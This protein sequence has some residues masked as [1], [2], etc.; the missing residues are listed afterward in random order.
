MRSDRLATSLGHVVPSPGLRDLREVSWP[1]HGV[2]VKTIEKETAQPS[3]TRC[4]GHCCK[5]FPLPFGPVELWTEYLEVRASDKVVRHDPVEIVK[6]A[7][8]VVY[9][10]ATYAPP[11]AIFHNG[12]TIKHYYTCRYH[13]AAT[14][15]C[16]NYENRPNMCSDYPYGQ[17]CEHGNACTWDEA[18]N[19]THRRHL[20]VIQENAAKA[21]EVAA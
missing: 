19:G 17:P 13:D 11:G 14:G 1:V 12:T 16:K 3:G 2:G 15:D 8:M 10:G 7:E 20:P 21:A 5:R 4:S 9:L 18:R 6:V